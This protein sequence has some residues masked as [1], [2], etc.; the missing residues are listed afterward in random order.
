MPTL[1]RFWEKNLVVTWGRK[2]IE[3]STTKIDLFLR[4]YDDLFYIKE[5]GIDKLDAVPSNA[6]RTRRRAFWKSISRR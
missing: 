1:S 6:L 5:N 2:I 4:R 3:K